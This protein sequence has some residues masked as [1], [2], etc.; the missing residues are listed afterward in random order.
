MIK[1][2]F[3][4]DNK[5]VE[6]QEGETLL[7][8]AVRN[9]VYIHTVCGGKAS[10][11]ECKVKIFDGNEY[12]TK[13][14]FDEQKVIGNAFHITK[15]RLSCQAKGRPE[16][17]QDL[18]NSKLIIID[19]TGHRPLSKEEVLEKKNAKYRKRFDT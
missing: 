13:S 2:K 4:P 1:I 15:L 19:T 8:C 18:E 6:L 11:V 12:L 3:V 5:L 7:Q 16:E 10:C 14:D 9:G 17:I